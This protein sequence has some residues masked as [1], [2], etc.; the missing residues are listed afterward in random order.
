MKRLGLPNG[1]LF[2]NY[3]L[4]LSKVDDFRCFAEGKCRSFFPRTACAPY[5]VDIVLRFVRELVVDDMAYVVDINPAG[6]YVGRHKDLDASC[7]ETV[8]C[9]LAGSL[10][11]VAM[12]II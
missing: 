8:K 3:P 7:V 4:D 10:C 1:K 12:Q 9:L 5:A 2:L 6:C 11:L